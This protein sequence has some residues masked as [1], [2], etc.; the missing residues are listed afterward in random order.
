MV[1]PTFNPLP[2]DCGMTWAAVWCLQL[3]KVKLL[4][5]ALGTSAKD[6]AELDAVLAQRARDLLGTSHVDFPLGWMPGEQYCGFCWIR[7]ELRWGAWTINFT[8]RFSY[9]IL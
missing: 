4:S 7:M 2:I 1:W 3:E 6:L 5:A 8:T 9:V